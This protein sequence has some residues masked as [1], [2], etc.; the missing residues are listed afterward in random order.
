MLADVVGW[1]AY[2]REKP[3]LDR[4]DGLAAYFVLTGSRFSELVCEGM[5]DAA[6]RRLV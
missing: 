1:M 6:G 4:L 5:E 3:H 2:G